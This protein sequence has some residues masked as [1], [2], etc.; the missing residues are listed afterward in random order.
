MTETPFPLPTAT[1][2]TLNALPPELLRLILLDHA[3]LRALARLSAVNRLFRSLVTLLLSPQDAVVQLFRSVLPLLRHLD[4]PFD[5]V[6]DKIARW[7]Y[8][9][10]V[11]VLLEGK[12]EEGCCCAVCGA[13]TGFVS[14]R[15]RRRVCKGCQGGWRRMMGERE[16][17]GED[18]LYE[19]YFTVPYWNKGRVTASLCLDSDAG[20]YRLEI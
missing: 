8:R 17:G 11:R 18:V 10:A 7:G 9:D 4:D 15:G 16:E 13:R 2:G 5:Y 3:D 19:I 14:P 12:E 6:V 20:V 1:L